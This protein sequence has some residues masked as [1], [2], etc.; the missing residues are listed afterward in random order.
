MKNLFRLTATVLGFTLFVQSQ[1]YAEDL[2]D[3]FEPS[4]THAYAGKYTVTNGG[5]V[6]YIK[7]YF[8]SDVGCS[9]L[10]DIATVTD[11]GTGFNFANGQTININGD[12][13]GAL[14][15]NRGITVTN[16]QCLKL[17]MDGSA[18]SSQGISC[19]SFTDETC[20]N[21]G[22]PICTSAQTKSVTWGASPTQC[23][24][25][26]AYLSNTNSDVVKCDVDP[27][28]GAF[29]SCADLSTGITSPIDLAVHNGF[30]HI[31]SADSDSAYKCAISPSTGAF[32]S[33]TTTF[34]NAVAPAGL[35]INLGYA[36]LSYIDNSLSKC[37]IAPATGTLSSCSS[38]GSGFS[39]PN[40]IALSNGF[41]YTVNFNPAGVIQCAVSSTGTLSSCASTGSGF[42]G[43]M[44]IRLADGFAFVANQGNSTVSV[45]SV[46]AAAGT[47][48]GC[49]TS[50]SGF[51]NPGGLGFY[52]GF[53]YVANGGNNTV[54][55]CTVNSS[56]G[57]LS[58]CSTTGSG[59]H[60]PVGEIVFY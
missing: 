58:S 45:C 19:Q 33:C 32:S 59:F 7:A 10:L 56:T 47:L 57:A 38:T 28:T 17:Y 51:N 30:A 36:F 4:P 6:H 50:G 24:N 54:S 53:L 27:S 23:T 49:S 2:K 41:S 5:T 39:E 13:V 48:S 44:H 26:V 25:R 18:Q 20:T 12:A 60:T 3:F 11:N 14:A 52:N 40:S 31:I 42:N 15:S 22:S 9:T 8:Y 55:Q 21:V 1:S 46:N 34:D 29:S 35:A 43:P 37:S 16:I